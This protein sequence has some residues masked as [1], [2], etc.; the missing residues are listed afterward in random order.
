LVR[1][2]DWSE[3]VTILSGVRWTVILS[4]IAFVGGGVF[5]LMIALL[6]T[7][8]VRSLER[9]TAAYIEFFQGTPLLMQLFL[10]FY[11]LPVLGVRVNPWLAAGVALTFHASAFLG[12]IWRGGIQAVPRGQSEAAQALGLRYADR[13]RDVVLPQALRLSVAPT[14]SFLVQLIK[15]TS[16]AAIIGF[17]ELSRS[18]QI[19]ASTTYRPLLAYGLAAAVYFAICFPLSRASARLERRYAL[20]A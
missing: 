14:V 5:G 18:A 19:V 10:V 17:V 13:M 8:G 4:L 20:R 3:I 12:E 6:R 2:F 11:G 9:V 7:S 1:A 16:L 15:G